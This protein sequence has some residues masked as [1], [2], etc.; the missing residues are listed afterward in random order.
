MAEVIDRLVEEGYL[1]LTQGFGSAKLVALGSTGKS[2]LKP[3]TAFPV[4]ILP[5]RPR[6]GTN[7]EVEE[8]L[9]TLRLELSVLEKRAPYG[10]F[11]NLVLADLAAKRPRSLAELGEISGFGEARIRKYGRKILAAVKED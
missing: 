1:T 6:L 9:R 8:R 11:P 3:G 2:A 7:P 4:D 10:I 5:S